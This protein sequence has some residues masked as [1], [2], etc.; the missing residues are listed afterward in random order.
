MALYAHWVH[1]W[2]VKTSLRIRQCD[3]VLA[4]SVVQNM[5]VSVSDPAAISGLNPVKL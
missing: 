2:Y 3:A 4:G 5:F 1:Y